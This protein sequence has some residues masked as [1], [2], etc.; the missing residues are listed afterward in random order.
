MPHLIFKLICFELPD[1]IC[2][3][4]G[5]ERLDIWQQKYASGPFSVIIF[6]GRNVNVM[7]KVKY[8]A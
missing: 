6:S 2:K 5:K 3:F 8:I 1:L 4:A 7:E